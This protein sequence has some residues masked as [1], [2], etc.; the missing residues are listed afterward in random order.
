MNK[1]L[2]SVQFYH[3]VVLGFV[4]VLFPYLNNFTDVSML[5]FGRAS[6]WAAW[7]IV[8]GGIVILSELVFPLY[9]LIRIIAW[10]SIGAGLMFAAVA[11]PP[12]ALFVC[13]GLATFW[14][15]ARIAWGVDE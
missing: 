7:Y 1:V 12:T 4:L 6:V 13:V 10:A 9:R 5:D 15:A 14:Q 2:D 3:F 11:W 8:V